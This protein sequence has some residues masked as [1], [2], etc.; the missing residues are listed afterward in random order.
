MLLTAVLF[1][2]PL[3]GTFSVLN[4]IALFKGSTAALPFGTI[5]IIVVLWA[6]VTFPLTVLGV[7][8]RR[9]CPAAAPSLLRSTP[10]LVVRLP[11]PLRSQHSLKCVEDCNTNLCLDA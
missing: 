4:T 11:L 10:G 1:C 9:R 7:R 2:G 6:L 8:Q 5:L 3:L